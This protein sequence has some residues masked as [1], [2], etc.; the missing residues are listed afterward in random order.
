MVVRLL[1]RY[2]GG[3]FDEE[4]ASLYYRC[5]CTYSSPDT[6]HRVDVDF[7]RRM[8]YGAS[9]FNPENHFLVFLGDKLV[10]YVWA[11]FSSRRGSANVCIDPDLSIDVRR[12]VLDRVFDEIRGEALR[13]GR[14]PIIVFHAG[15]EYGELYYLLKSIREPLLIEYSGVLMELDALDKRFLLEGSR[16]REDVIV[17]REDGIEKAGTIAE[18]FNDAFS[19]YPWFMEWSV[20]DARKWYKLHKMTVFIA[21]SG[22][23]EPLGYCDISIYEN[24]YGERAGYLRTLAVKRSYQG[25]GIGTYL[26]YQAIKEVMETGVS[27]IYLDAV[28]GIE[29]FYSRRGF[30]PVH[31][32]ARFIY[33]I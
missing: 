9:W 8:W 23:G 14:S 5:N 22:K 13:R 27:K 17:R 1:W 18:I 16:S 4:I 20:D 19:V 31:R 28:Y 24:Y 7:I 2:R 25:R 15:R 12:M 29:K 11:E 10:G 6:C 3:R 32:Y 33:E 30:K 21:Y 26:L